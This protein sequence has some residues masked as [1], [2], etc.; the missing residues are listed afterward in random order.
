MSFPNRSRNLWLSS[1]WSFCSATELQQ[2]PE[3]LGSW[4]QCFCFQISFADELE[5]TERLEHSIR[6]RYCYVFFWLQLTPSKQPDSQVSLNS[7]WIESNI[8][9]FNFVGLTQYFTGIGLIT[10]L[11]YLPC[12]WKIRTKANDWH[13]HNN[14]NPN[15]P[16]ANQLAI[17]RHGWGVELG[18][19]KN[20]PSQWSGQDLNLGPPDCKSSVLTVW[21]LPAWSYP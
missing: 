3:K 17:Y 15:W 11:Q 6:L 16:E 9:N 1:N 13:K 19:I 10:S 21:P 5:K 2:T 7:I 18:S 4:Q 8:T 20:K 12:G 14:K